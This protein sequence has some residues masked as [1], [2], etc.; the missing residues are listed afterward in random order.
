MVVL[1]SRSK[2]ETNPTMKT[3][4]TS[5]RAYESFVI[6]EVCA[7]TDLCISYCNEEWLFIQPT[8]VLTHIYT[9]LKLFY[10]NCSYSAGNGQVNAMSLSTATAPGRLSQTNV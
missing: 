3:N 5:V 2:Y 8:S 6:L 1:Q 7:F 4:T 9:N 10:A